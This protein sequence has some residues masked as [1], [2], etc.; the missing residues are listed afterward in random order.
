[1]LLRLVGVWRSRDTSARREFRGSTLDPL[2]GEI[3]A[4]HEREKFVSAS[5]N[6]RLVGSESSYGRRRGRSPLECRR[7]PWIAE[8]DSLASPESPHKIKN[9]NCLRGDGDDCSDGDHVLE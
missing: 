6:N 5:I 8:G 3:V 4:L 2:R 7:A 9:E 1:M